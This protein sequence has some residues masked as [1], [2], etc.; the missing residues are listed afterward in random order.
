MDMP[1]ELASK[2]R[3][4]INANHPRIQIPTIVEM[5]MY[6]I[7]DAPL[8]NEDQARRLITLTPKVNAPVEMLLMPRIV[9]VS[10]TSTYSIALVVVVTRRRMVKNILDFGS[11]LEAYDG[12]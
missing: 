12:N 9:G 8:H 5:N 7:W 10:E 11:G 6:I 1:Q 3:N 2:M 4:A